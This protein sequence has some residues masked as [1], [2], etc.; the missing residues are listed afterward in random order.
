MEN[1]VYYGEYSLDYWIELILSKNIILP[2]YQ[3]NF[4]WDESK[5]EKLITSLKNKEFVPPVIIGSFTKNGFKENL[6]IDGQQRLTSILLS[7]LGFFPDRETYKKHSKDKVRKYIDEND[8]FAGETDSSTDVINW[9]F[10]DLLIED[11]LTISKI[12]STL[13]KDEYFK[14]LNNDNEIDNSFLKNTFLGFSYLVPSNS[15]R[16]DQQRYYSSVFRNINRQGMSLTGQESREAL[17]YLDESKTSFFKPK[18]INLIEG[19]LSIDFIRYLS[20]LSQYK[21]EGSV[22]NLCSGFG[23]R[24][25]KLEEYYEN[26]INFIIGDKNIKYYISYEELFDT[27]EQLL[28]CEQPHSGRYSKMSNFISDSPLSKKTFDSIIDCDLYYFG[29]IYLIIF[30]NKNIDLEKWSDITKKI[31][32]SIEEFKAPYLDKQGVPTYELSKAVSRSFHQK[33]PSALKYLR[34]RVEKSIAIY[35]EF[36]I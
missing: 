34:E 14:A 21:K 22:Q 12:K 6:L 2:D 26:Y 35:R 33:N 25:E 23:G 18:F 8:D 36:E 20:I 28:S 13:E 16:G 24:K 1:K 32:K 17:Y 7:V 29:L 5:R 30:E 19:E 3:R 10:N 15:Q 27:N 31:E 11:N 4:S 9:T